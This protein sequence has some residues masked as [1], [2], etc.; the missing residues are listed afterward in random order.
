MRTLLYTDPLFREHRTGAHPERSQRLEKIEAHLAERKLAERCQAAS[1]QPAT[2]ERLE[3]NHTRAHIEAVRRMAA[4]G[5]GN[6]EA[7]TVVSEKSYDAALLAV[8]AVCDATLEVGESRAANALCL[9]RP[10]GHHAKETA[11][12]GFCLFNN[13]AVAARVALEELRMDRVLI[14]DWDVHHGN[15]TQDS[16]WDDGRVG[17][18]SIHRFPFY[19]GTGDV[20]ETGTGAARGMIRNVPVR[21]ETSRADFKA[22]FARELSDFT[23][24]IKPDLILVSAG[25]DA[26]RED[27]IGS[28]GLETEDF[29]ELSNV[30]L[31]LA[32]EYCGGRVVSTLEGGYHV[33]RLAESV[34]VHLE[35]LLAASEKG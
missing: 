21:F 18:F 6:I 29:V 17:F 23:A 8:G 26:H 25:F 31:K 22:K 9:V 12:M 30:V 3:R 7:D 4:A 16:F 24:R 20:D 35:C 13:V 1:W 28:L 5:G 33:D 10:P 32:E 27:P 15:G 2:L 14:V 11:P 19:P 34:G